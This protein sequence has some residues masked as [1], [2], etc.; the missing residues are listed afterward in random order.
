MVTICI[1][2]LA[3]MGWLRQTGTLFT[4][5][6]KFQQISHFQKGIY[7]TLKCYECHLIHS[8]IEYFRFFLGWPKAGRAARRT[9]FPQ[10]VRLNCQKLV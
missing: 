6:Y 8:K 1:T 2:F 4:K 7:E 10:K 9:F 3:E 5:F